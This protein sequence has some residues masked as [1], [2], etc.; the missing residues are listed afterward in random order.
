MFRFDDTPF[1]RIINSYRREVATY[2]AAVTHRAA[3][4]PRP[5]RYHQWV[6]QQTSPS[7]V[8]GQFLP[9]GLLVI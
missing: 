1:A 2:R 7:T 3:S 9:R 4:H 8:F 5:T 6:M